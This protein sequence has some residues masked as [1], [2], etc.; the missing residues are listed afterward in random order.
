M[1]QRTM[2]VNIVTLIFL[3]SSYWCITTIGWIAYAGQG[4]HNKIHGALNTLHTI[5][6]YM[7]GCIDLKS[8]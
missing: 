2:I 4:P 8:G 7:C 3:Y 5:K 1:I 6:A